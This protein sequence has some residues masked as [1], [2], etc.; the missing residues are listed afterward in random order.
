MSD[1][2]ICG[3]RKQRH[4]DLEGGEAIVRSMDPVDVSNW[5]LGI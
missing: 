1:A 5:S 2:D 4:R 3:I